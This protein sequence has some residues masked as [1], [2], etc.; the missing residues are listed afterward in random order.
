MHQSWRGE[1]AESRSDNYISRSVVK[2]RNHVYHG[3]HVRVELH[4]SALPML[5]WVKEPPPA[6]PHR[7]AGRVL[8]R[9]RLGR[10]GQD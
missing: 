3:K 4:A 5:G 10:K 1:N 8:L 6:V 2:L 7:S 9:A